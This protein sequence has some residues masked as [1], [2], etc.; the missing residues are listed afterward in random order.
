MPLPLKSL[1]ICFGALL[2][3][4]AIAPAQ[5]PPTKD[6]NPRPHAILPIHQAR[7]RPRSSGPL[8]CYAS[9]GKLCIYL[10]SQSTPPP[11]V[12]PA[13]DLYQLF[14]HM[15]LAPATARDRLAA[16][17]SDAPANDVPERF[18]ALAVLAKVA[19][20]PANW[21]KPTITRSSY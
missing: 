10:E 17:E 9:A 12:S 7:A 16:L 14:A 2:S 8:R 1:A 6:L 5:E 19:S 20:T 21:I 13:H 3:T 15:N 4:A 18:Y 11:S